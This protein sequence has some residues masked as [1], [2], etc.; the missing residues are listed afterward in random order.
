[1]EAELGTPVPD[2]VELNISPAPELLPVLLFLGVRL[3]LE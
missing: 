1:V 3:I 2:E